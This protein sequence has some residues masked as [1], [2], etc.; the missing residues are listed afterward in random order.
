MLLVL[1]IHFFAWPPGGWLGVDMFFVLSGFLITT[2]LLEEWDAHRRISLRSFYRR[3]FLRLF[4]AL[5]VLIVVYLLYLTARIFIGRQTGLSH[6]VL[7]QYLG[8]IAGPLYWQNFAAAFHLPISAGLGH[9]WSLALEEQFYLLWPPLLLVMLRKGLGAVRIARILLWTI[10]AICVWR[11]AL[12]LGGASSDRLYFAPDTRFDS[13]LVGC[14]GGIWFVASSVRDK[15][16]WSS[17]FAKL[18]PWALVTIGVA[19]VLSDLL[20]DVYFAGGFT[21]VAVLSLVV[22]LDGVLR[23]EG[24]LAGFLSSKT[25]RWLGRLSYSLYLW[26]LFVIAVAKQYERSFVPRL[27]TAGRAL[28]PLI[29][30]AVSLT[31]AY[32]SYRFVERPFLKLKRSYEAVEND[33]PVPAAVPVAELG[34]A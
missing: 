9:L 20:W 2:L 31:C 21:V 8:A 14:L 28:M 18:A 24:R 17:Y 16:R 26:H 4:P 25:M 3:R 22:I 30:I 29:E 13:I 33:E 1:L 34:T 7:T 5:A 23:G 6:S 10:G 11:L 12:N 15:R 32:L 27:S 19:L